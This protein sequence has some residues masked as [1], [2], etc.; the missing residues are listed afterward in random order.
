[1]HIGHVAIQAPDVAATAEHAALALGLEQ[2]EAEDSHA[3]LTANAKHHELQI[4]RGSAGM[5]HIGLEVADLGELEHWK[6]RSVAAGGELISEGPEEPGLRDAF[7][8]AGPGGLVYEV[9][10]P[11]AI[12]ELNVAR[13]IG[14]NARKLGH[15]TLFSDV[16]EEIV[17]FTVNGLGFRISDQV[18]PVTWMRCDV[19]HHGVAVRGGA[20]GGTAMHHYAFELDGWD[21]MRRY[22]D[23]L[24]VRGERVVWGPGRHGPGFN[25]YTYL[26]EPNG[27]LIEGYADLQKIEDEENY[28]PIDWDQIPG[29]F[30]LWGPQMPDNFHDF[31]IP[32]LGPTA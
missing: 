24:A 32:A 12:T 21:G 27:G 3:F 29:A 10:T 14:R 20:S 23:E 31:A 1:M 25:L 19:D 17:D 22:L 5:D 13:Q 2:T 11:M 9:Y 26:P 16:A 7:R 6:E 8:V 18:G 15:V 28:V 4:Q 30:N